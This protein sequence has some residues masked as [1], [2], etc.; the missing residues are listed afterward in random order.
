MQF[1]LF[2]YYKQCWNYIS[3]QFR[4]FSWAKLPYSL[5]SKCMN[6]F[7]LLITL[8]NAVQKDSTNLHTY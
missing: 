6:I 3:L 7:S 5:G 2:H 8:P 1:P 4:L